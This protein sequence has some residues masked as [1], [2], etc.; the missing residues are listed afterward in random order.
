MSFS[1]PRVCD[2]LLR[3]ICCRKVVPDPASLM[4]RVSYELRT[5][6]NGIVGYAEF[7]ENRTVEPMTNFTAKIIRESSSNLKR[8]CNSYFDLQFLQNGQIQL[9]KTQ[10]NF[11]TL[12]Q[13]V[14]EAHQPYAFE[15][16]ISLQLFCEQDALSKS[17]YSDVARLHQI[18]DA[19]IFNA[20]KMSE[21]W[22]VIGIQLSWQ[23]D[24]NLLELA[25]DSVQTKLERKKLKFL[26]KFWNTDD[27]Q[28][29]LQDGPGVEMALAKSLIQLAGISAAYV[30]NQNDVG[31]LQLL[32]KVSE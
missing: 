5:S 31:T 7:L 2:W 14:M 26:E 15:R 27:Y 1:L 30:V 22:D 13:S 28:F 9:S 23:A 12:L 21:T 11:S 32:V 3:K 16:G 25:I 19:V 24:K 6:L 29:Q 20:L 8:S 18:L 17:I 10:F 4:A